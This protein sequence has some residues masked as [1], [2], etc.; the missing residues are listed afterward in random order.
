MRGYTLT[1]TSANTNYR[2]ATLIAAI[3]AAETTNVSSITISSDDA[4][5]GVVLVGDAELA[6][7]RYGARLLTGES[8]SFDTGSGINDQ[9]TA[10]KYLRSATAA[11]VIHVSLV[12]T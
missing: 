3:N 7:T 9:S 12:T 6:S 8:M 1:L 4:N 11:Q 2:L 5:A 10:N